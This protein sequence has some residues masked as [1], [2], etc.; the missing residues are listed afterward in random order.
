MSDNA[1]D[2]RIHYQDEAPRGARIKVIGVGGGGNN[3]V[4]RM[5]AAGVEGVE[6]ISANTDV[7]A[8]QLSNAPIK[9]QLGV[10]LTSGLGAGANP[11]V[12]RRAALEDS[13]KIIEAL[14]GAD[15]V[16]VTAGLGGGTGTGAAPVIASLASEMGALTVAVVTR[17]FAFEGKRRMMQAERGMQ[18]LLESV[19]TLIVIPNEKLLAVA[20][21]AGFFESFRIA[22]DVLRQGVQG[23]SDIITIP[24]VINRDFADVKTTMAGMGYAVMGTARGAGENRAM[25]A[26]IAAMASPLLEAGA[27]DGARGVLINITGSSNLKLSEVN[28]A[29]TIIQNAAHE[30][31]NIIF[32][33][34]Q[35]ERMG[36]EVRITVIA[37]G[38][39]QE[40][41]ERRARMLAE[42][43]LPG[44]DFQVPIR[45]RSVSGR[46]VEAPALFASEEKEM[47][48]SAPP[49]EVEL[50]Q[51]SPAA[52]VEAEEIDDEAE[53][54]EIELDADGSADDVEAM[55]LEDDV[56]P[57]AEHRTEPELIPV[58]ASVFDDDFFRASRARGE[59]AA[60]AGVA[61]EA[62]PVAAAPT[63]DARLFAGVS[64]SHAEPAD[65]DEL[66]I[67]AFLRR[68]Q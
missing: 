4:N 41:P 12:G 60:R 38:F 5:I 28:E 44:A 53:A 32:G 43:T 20:K 59:A 48:Q 57:E 17:P 45:G 61:T 10:K 62:A 3:A 27:I 14:E 24:G 6:F 16:F 46:G 22:D 65:A 13:D 47:R 34:V 58:S 15:M 66:D 29:S 63:G 68:S 52:K 50:A 25:D 26:A 8:L 31:C 1:D 9:L 51:P 11:D 23:I 33:A 55:E 40:M 42:S 67:P 54:A 7:Q 36:D 18:E 30:D 21:D 39:R 37:T 2:L 64:A 49:R 56:A 35:D 19:D